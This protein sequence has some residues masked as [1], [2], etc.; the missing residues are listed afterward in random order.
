[1]PTTHSDWEHPQGR[2]HVSSLRLGASLMA[3]VPLRPDWVVLQDRTGWD[4]ETHKPPE[5]QSWGPGT[6]KD[7][8]LGLGA[9]STSRP[10]CAWLWTPC[11]LLLAALSSHPPTSTGH[12]AEQPS[13]P[14]GEASLP[15]ALISEAG[16]TDVSKLFCSALP[17]SQKH[18]CSPSRRT[19]FTG[20]KQRPRE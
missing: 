13:D 14:S 19:P 11:F 10:G 4:E 2:A 5:Q 18:V 20:R 8:R 17:A 15:S 12:A 9:I 1:M 7:A 6:V 3:E 16:R